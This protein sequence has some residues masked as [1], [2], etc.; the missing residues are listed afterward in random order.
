MGTDHELV[1]QQ[2]QPAVGAVRVKVSKSGRSFK[3]DRNRPVLEGAL[4]AGLN[5]P[6]SCKGGNCGSCRARLLEGEIRYPNGR[7]LGLSD[8]E[9]EDGLILLCQAQAESDLSIE[10]FEASAADDTP[11]KRLP[12]RIERIERLAHDVAA[13]YLR[14]P[15]AERF[16]FKPGQYLDILLSKGRRRSFSIASPPH[17]ARPVELHVRLAPGG[18]FTESLFSGRMAGA[19]LDIEGPLGHFIYREPPPPGAGP[20]AAAPMLLVGGGTGLAPLLSIV[21]H[22]TERGAER[23]AERDMTLYW[24]VRAERDL[25]AHASLESLARRTPTFR[26]VPVLSEGSAQWR[27][28]RGFVHAA[29]LAEL[30]DLSRHEVYASGPPAM[31]EALR[32]DFSARGVDP[33]RLWFDSFDYAPDTLEHQRTSADTRS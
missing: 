33:A 31:I 16:D 26:Y 12:G 14:L 15:A 28:R 11:I 10:T 9:V 25:Y 23:E 17:D 13:V 3:V 4:Q 27:G 30:Q 24:G 29:A 19:L 5:L 20:G 18:E 22:V 6:H 7:P 8:A 1:G 32:R 21:R 2:A